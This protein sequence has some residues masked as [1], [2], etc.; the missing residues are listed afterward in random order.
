MGEYGELLKVHRDN[1]NKY[2]I[3]GKD[4]VQHH[5]SSVEPLLNSWWDA[6]KLWEEND[7]FNKALK[8]KRMTVRTFP[9][10]LGVPKDATVPH[11]RIRLIFDSW[12]N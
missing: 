4:L 6:Y 12:K 7:T 3:L 9:G 11:P 10:T 2:L 1:L 8:N 5:W